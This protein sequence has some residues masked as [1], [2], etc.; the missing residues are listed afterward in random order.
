MWTRIGI[1]TGVFGCFSC[2]LD[3]SNLILDTGVCKKNGAFIV[4]CFRKTKGITTLDNNNNTAYFANT[5]TL[6]WYFV[7]REGLNSL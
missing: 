6:V 5:D 7:P 4:V 2:V 1:G 3:K